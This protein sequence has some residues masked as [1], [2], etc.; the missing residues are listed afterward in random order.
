MP[1]FNNARNLTAIWFIGVVAIIGGIVLQV[2]N[3]TWLISVPLKA[4]FRQTK[5]KFVIR[6]RMMKWIIN[7]S[8]IRYY[9]S[10]NKLNI[11]K[12]SRKSDFLPIDSILI[13][14]ENEIN[15]TNDSIKYRNHSENVENASIGKWKKYNEYI[16]VLFTINT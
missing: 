11:E 12:Y 16:Q 13:K 4:F 14:I 9:P 1:S 5:D 7:K 6:L 2:K 3:H 8:C 15:N 10:A